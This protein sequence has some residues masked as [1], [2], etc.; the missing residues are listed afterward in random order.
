LAF[1]TLLAFLSYWCERL[2]LRPLISGALMT[3]G[4]DRNSRSAQNQFDP[5]NYY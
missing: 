4:D 3:G 5:A 2:Q 1:P